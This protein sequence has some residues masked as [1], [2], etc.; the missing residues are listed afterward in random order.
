MVV[1]ARGIAGALFAVLVGLTL[2]TFDY[3]EGTSYLSTDPEVCGNCHI[4]W[5]Q[6]DSWQKS[7]H[8]TS[9]VCVDCHLPNKGVAKYLSKLENGYYHSK[10]F[11][12]QNFPEPI[13]ITPKNA[14]I[15]HANCL[16]CHGDLVHAAGGAWS[17]EAPRCVR[18]HATVGHGDPLGLGG[19]KDPVEHP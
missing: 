10:A 16:R 8:H 5:P 12:L 7:S 17:E 19:P 11:T 9:A 14:R 3:A 18:C 15:L 6:L 1:T 4:M 13:A 2:V